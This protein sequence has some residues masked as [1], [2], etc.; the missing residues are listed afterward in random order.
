M[1]GSLPRALSAK[2]VKKPA[3]FAYSFAMNTVPSV[4]QK[5]KRFELYVDVS[6]LWMKR[7]SNTRIFYTTSINLGRLLPDAPDPAGEDPRTSLIRA[8]SARPKDTAKDR[9]TQAMYILYYC[10]DARTS[11]QVHRTWAEGCGSRC[12]SLR[13]T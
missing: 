8:V 6:Y 12:T 7:R 4:T 11:L 5:N 10:R 2:S 9:K 1:L 13:G 3:E